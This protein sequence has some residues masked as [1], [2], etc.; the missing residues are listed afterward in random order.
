MLSV[1]WI[2]FVVFPFYTHGWHKSKCLGLYMHWFLF[3]G[4]FLYLF[5]FLNPHFVKVITLMAYFLS[6]PKAPKY[7]VKAVASSNFSVLQYDQKSSP[8]LQL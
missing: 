3:I 4:H 6:F 1:L 7:A 5:F 8:Y 2:F